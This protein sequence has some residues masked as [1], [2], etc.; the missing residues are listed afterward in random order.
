MLESIVDKCGIDNVLL[1]LS[2]MCGD[3]SVHV[4]VA[5]QDPH[6]AKRWCTVADDLS[7][8]VPKAANL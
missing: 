5:W 3:K 2:V 6:L 7:A 1:A 4:A 8:I